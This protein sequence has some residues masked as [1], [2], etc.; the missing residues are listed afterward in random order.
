MKSLYFW[1]KSDAKISPT[2]LHLPLLNPMGL[3]FNTIS[4]IS[5]T[6]KTKLLCTDTD[7]N[8]SIGFR[9]ILKNKIKKELR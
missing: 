9:L 6:S 8:G 3:V 4:I 2:F 5:R 7:D 1:L